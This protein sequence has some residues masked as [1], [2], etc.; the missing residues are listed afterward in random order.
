[1]MTDDEIGT[2][3][4]IFDKKK[5]ARR[6]WDAQW[7]EIARFS[8]PGK[9]DFITERTEGDPQRNDC[10]YDPT[11]A[12]SN[13]VLASHIH[14]ALTSPDAQW[15]ELGFRDDDMAQVEGAKEWLE[16]ASGTL[17]DQINDS[18]F[19]AVINETYQNLVAFGTAV[20]ES[21]H[22][23]TAQ[24][25]YRLVFRDIPLCD[26]VLIENVQGVVDT[27]FHEVRLSARQAQ[28]Q[29]GDDAPDKVHELM[30]KN[31]EED[32][33][34]LKHVAPNPDH[35][36]QKTL[37]PE[38][39]RY[40]CVWMYNKKQV[41]QEYYYEFPYHCP[42]WSKMTREPY[43]YGPG[44]LAISEVKTLNEAKKLG[45]RDW[46]KS[47]DWPLI[48][49]ESGVMADIDQD[50]SG[51]TPVENLDAIGELPGGSRRQ[52]TMTYG[53][54]SRRYIQSI[55]HIDQLILPERPN[56]TATEVQIRYTM[57][58]RVLGPTAGR[59]ESELLN[60]MITRI[61]GM[62]YRN[63]AIDPMPQGVEGAQ[64]DVKYTGPL[65]RAQK[66]DD[67]QAIER[68]ITVLTNVAGV[69]PDLYVA[70]RDRFK[71]G[72]AFAVLAQQYGAPE[73]VLNSEREAQKMMKLRQA[74]QEKEAVARDAELAAATAEAQGQVAAVPHMVEQARRAAHGS[75]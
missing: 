70:M 65:A 69:D 67:A 30:E 50:P 46:A 36:P 40:R 5:S 74:E 27:I 22:T 57:M 14:S 8:L 51:M 34:F 6:N 32:I 31:P 53:E 7:E 60:P 63:G 75:A 1:M 23:Q 66:S 64:T 71:P 21:T 11:A 68:L 17:M 35:D 10:L 38:N 45:L 48:Y 44:L 20:L 4:R 54:E 56:A 61:F 33:T 12:V 73:E 43:G 62:S 13:H 26:V 37:S 72:E 39:R 42:R 55:Y 18:N 41:L 29:F 58:Q 24:E 16:G 15:F 25:G 2:L 47:I 19:V 59:L 49:Q 3:Y 9:A 28:K 52:V